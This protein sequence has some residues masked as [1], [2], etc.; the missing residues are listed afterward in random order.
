M[1]EV[2]RLRFLGFVEWCRRTKRK[3]H[4]TRKDLGVR[5]YG[6]EVEDT[7]MYPIIREAFLTIFDKYGEVWG[8][9]KRSGEGTYWHIVEDEV[10]QRV[11][12]AMFLAHINGT[13]VNIVGDK[14]HPNIC[15]NWMKVLNK[16]RGEILSG[17]PRIEEV[18]RLLPAPDSQS[19]APHLIYCPHCGTKAYV[20]GLT[21]DVEDAQLLEGLPEQ[22]ADTSEQPAGVRLPI[23][24]FEDLSTRAHNLLRRIDC[25]T[26]Q[27]FL[28]LDPSRLSKERGVGATTTEEI[29]ER[30]EQL[31]SEVVGAR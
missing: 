24:G 27:E 26:I 25:T 1:N 23:K 31:R 11:V 2:S 28:D 22:V 21:G 14:N 18:P 15:L 4:I 19:I 30:Q 8:P 17:Y 12:V 5:F 3:D 29:R 10:D 16:P 7:R 20:Q 9:V 13:L 6:K